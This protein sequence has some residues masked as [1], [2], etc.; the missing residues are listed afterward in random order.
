MAP[1]LETR[2]Q[3]FLSTFSDL[4]PYPG[5]QGLTTDE[6]AQ[7]VKYWNGLNPSDQGARNLLDSAFHSPRGS[8]A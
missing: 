2:F 7:L 6:R 8:S 5:P 3:Q 1:S 4:G